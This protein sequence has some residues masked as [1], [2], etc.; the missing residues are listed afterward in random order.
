MLAWL[1][2]AMILVPV[3]SGGPYF[4]LHAADSMTLVRRGWLPEEAG[5]TASSEL[6]L[7]MVQGEVESVQL[8]IVG[9]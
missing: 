8:V 6:T 2:T 7:E 5:Q 3:L 9:V 4:D 1:S